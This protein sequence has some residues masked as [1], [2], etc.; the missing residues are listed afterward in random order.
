M[1]FVR[2][3]FTYKSANIYKCKPLPACLPACI[4]MNCY[5]TQNDFHIITRT[6]S[7]TQTLTKA[8]S[9]EID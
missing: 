6:G 7:N 4:Y 1:W 2:L 3:N 5:P 8:L 9:T